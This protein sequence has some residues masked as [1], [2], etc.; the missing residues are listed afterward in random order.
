MQ[1]V[2]AERVVG[3]GDQDVGEVVLVAAVGGRDVDVPAPV[4]LDE[5]G[6][7]DLRRERAVGGRA[8][9]D[10]LLPQAREPV[11]APDDDTRVGVGLAP[12]VAV[13]VADDE[14]VGP[15]GHGV[16]EQA[17]RQRRVAVPVERSAGGAP[18]SRGRAAGPSGAGAG[19][20]RS[21]RVARG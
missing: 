12:Q 21:A 18:R 17:V 11:R 13:T 3:V 9:H 1:G 16:D 15:L 8:P 19:R 7:P 2:R 20:P 5:L 6:C 10:V 14:R 4:E